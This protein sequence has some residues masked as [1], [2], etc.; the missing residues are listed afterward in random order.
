MSTFNVWI[1]SLATG[2]QAFSY[3]NTITNKNQN[4]NSKNVHTKVGDKVRQF[5]GD[6]DSFIMEV[7]LE[8]L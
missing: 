7:Q 1:F 8:I 2:S 5:S 4:K 6:T 3:G